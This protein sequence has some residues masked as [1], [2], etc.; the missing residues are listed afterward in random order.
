[1]NF[2]GYRSKV[3]ADE[4]GREFYFDNAKFILITLVV[5]AHAISPLKGYFKEVETLWT[6]I[7]SLHM[8]CLIFI[9]GYFAKSY[10]KDGVV[11]TQRLVTYV[12]YYL[13]SQIAVSLFEYFVLGDVKISKSF[14]W[15]RSSLWYLACLCWWFLVLPYI[16][17]LKPPYVLMTAFICALIIGY[18]TKSGNIMSISRAVNHFP[19]FL[20]GYYFKK[21]WLY[22]FRNIWTQIAAVLIIA[23]IAIWTHLNLDMIPSRIITSNYNYYES[24]LQVLNTK[25]TMFLNRLIFYIIAIVLCACFMLL[26]PRGKAFFTRW[27]SRTLQVYILHRFLYLSELKYK[28]YEPFVSSKKGYLVLVLIAIAV[29]I[30]LSLKPFEYPFKLLGKI[31]LTRFERDEV[32]TKI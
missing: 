14:L 1:M 30:I 6:V 21:D 16:S 8:P 11:K 3:Y 18:D 2:L 4:R 28:W 15:P 5:L 25:P 10:I 22:K 7:N 26:V 20:I 29:T 13:A 27:G 17:R 23:G 32:K 19:F 31:K 9:S 24:Q 12:V